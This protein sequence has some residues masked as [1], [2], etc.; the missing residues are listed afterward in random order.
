MS[1]SLSKIKL[2]E[3]ELFGSELASETFRASEPHGLCLQNGFCQKVRYNKGD[4]I[5]WGN[6]PLDHNR[7]FPCV[8]F[9]E[10]ACLVEEYRE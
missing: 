10:L 1:N 5:A 3:S 4:W 6:A 7:L 2:S 8:L 9:F